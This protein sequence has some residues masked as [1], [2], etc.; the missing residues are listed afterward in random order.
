MYDCAAPL[1]GPGGECVSYPHVLIPTI[2]TPA[3]V[4]FAKQDDQAECLFGV[5][6][7]PHPSHQLHAELLS[8]ASRTHQ[9][10]QELQPT[11]L[12]VS[13][14]IEAAVRS[15]WSGAWVLPYGS[16][17]TGLS[18][19]SS[20]LDL[21]VL[22]FRGGDKQEAVTELAAVLEKVEG[23]TSVMPLPN[24]KIPV[25]KVIYISDNI[26]INVDVTLASTFSIKNF[27]IS[28]SVLNGATGDSTAQS[29]PLMQVAVDAT[30]HDHAGLAS[31]GLLRHYLQTYPTLRPLAVALKHMLVERGLSCTYTGGLSS[32]CLTLMLASFIHSEVQSDYCLS[33]HAM[34][35]AEAVCGE[36]VKDAELMKHQ[37]LGQLLLGFLYYFGY[38]FDHR[39][40]GVSLAASTSLISM[41]RRKD[42]LCI[43]KLKRKA[44]TL[45][46]T[47][48][49][50]P[51]NNI[52][53][54]VFAMWRIQLVFKE[55]F[56]KL[57]KLQA[58]ETLLS[59]LEG[60]Y[61]LSRV[62]KSTNL[63]PSVPV[64]P[65]TSTVVENIISSA[66]SA[67]LIES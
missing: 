9:T 42:P 56:Q 59:V 11:L 14:N 10:V 50:N 38:E 23:F 33:K 28:C 32:Y 24:A 12:R 64:A 62:A 3:H 61:P 41:G 67:L 21:V 37:G 48:P 49:F 16:F 45:V 55:V 25:I 44:R 30:V 20:D 52:A 17:V 47:D 8:F 51:H 60:P 31:V 63:V 57:V 66:P 46:I 4:A 40:Q 36:S 29:G 6:G 65:Q 19:P 26:S 35:R 43:Y 1:L 22:D 2:A 58:D 39:S 54:G 13:K 18:L 5:P 53:N 34:S 27:P 7:R 15:I